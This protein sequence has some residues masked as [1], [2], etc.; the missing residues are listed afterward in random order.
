MTKNL[1]LTSIV[2]CDTHWQSSLLLLQSTLVNFK[3]HLQ[4]VSQNTKELPNFSLIRKD[5]YCFLHFTG[6]RFQCTFTKAIVALGK[7]HTYSVLSLSSLPRSTTQLLPI[8]VWQNTDRYCRQR[9]ERQPKLHSSLKG[10]TRV[11]AAGI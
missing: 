10:K 4:L 11:L 5:Y 1:H 3:M 6:S 9:G 2:M 7:A 8:M